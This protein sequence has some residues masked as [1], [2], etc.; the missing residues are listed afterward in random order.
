MFNRSCVR[1]GKWLTPFGMFTDI[2]LLYIW[3]WLTGRVLS[4]GGVD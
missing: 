3:W 2:G 4:L 1:V